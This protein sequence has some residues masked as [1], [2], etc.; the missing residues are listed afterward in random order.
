[1]TV[2]GLPLVGDVIVTDVTESVNVV[3]A[4]PDHAPVAVTL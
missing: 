1:V 2:T 4:V 3:V